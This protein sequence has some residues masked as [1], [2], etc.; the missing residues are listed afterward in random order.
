MFR[1]AGFSFLT[2]SRARGH[3]YIGPETESPF[4]WPSTLGSAPEEQPRLGQ[5][6]PALVSSYAESEF[7]T[8]LVSACLTEVEPLSIL[9]IRCVAQDGLRYAAEIA[10]KNDMMRNHS[11]GWSSG[12]RILNH[13][14]RT[15]RSQCDVLSRVFGTGQASGDSEA[16]HG[17]PLSFPLSGK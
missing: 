14:V 11:S 17:V 4:L 6:R 1:A 2:H 5:A 12:C 13:R 7:V 3:S 16:S 15:H 10:C 9:S 8:A